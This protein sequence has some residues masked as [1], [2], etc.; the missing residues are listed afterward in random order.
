MAVMDK[1][2]ADEEIPFGNDEDFPFGSEEE[3]SFG[4]SEEPDA[5]K[6]AGRKKIDLTAPVSSDRK[7][8]SA[9][10]TDGSSDDAGEL[11]ADRSSGDGEEPAA[12]KDGE[13]TLEE[14]FSRLDNLAARLEQRDIPLEESFHLYKEGMDLLKFCRERIDTV[15]KKMQVIS[16]DGELSDFPQ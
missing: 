4:D 10:A 8:V 2:L 12:G 1:W 15:E 7:T 11:S 6:K 5:G 14:A 13:L 3:L 16:D 9:A